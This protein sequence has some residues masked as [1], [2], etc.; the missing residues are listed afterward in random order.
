MNLPGF[1]ILLILG[2]GVVRAQSSGD[3]LYVTNE[4][5]GELTIID[6]NSFAVLAQIPVGQ[7]PRGLK[8][9]P[10][11]QTIYVALSGSPKCPPTMPDEECDNV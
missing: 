2:T 10:D 4:D 5:S 3:R 9:S 11:G 7:R 6:G 1:L 8:V